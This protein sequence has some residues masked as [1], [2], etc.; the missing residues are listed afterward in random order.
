MTGLVLTNRARQALAEARRVDEVKDIRDQAEAV[1]AYAKQAGLGL[2]MINDAAEIKLRAER[3]AGEILADMEKQQGARDGKTGLHDVTPLPPRL[4]SLGIAK[5]ESARWQH[6]AAIPE[7]EFEQHVAKTKA[8]G[9]ELSTAG[10][11]RLGI[12]G[13]RDSKLAE[14]ALTLDKQYGIIYADPPWR[15]EHPP[16]GSTRRSIER[17]YPTLSLEEICALPVSELAALDSLLYLWAT[18]PKLRECLQVMDAWEFHYRTHFVWVKDKIGTGYHNRNQHELLLVGKR[19]EIPPP[20]ESERVSSVLI[21]PRGRHS[22]KPPQVY[23]WL[24]NWYPGIPKIELFAR[25]RRKGWE[26]WGNEL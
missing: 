6:M 1:R 7:A 18:A 23:D 11:L 2:E 13:R 22:E 14:I 9:K 20:P 4:S 25:N 12:N 5:H 10:V 16:M 3:R 15:Y 24:D 17:H 26:A 21:S 19:G 8:A